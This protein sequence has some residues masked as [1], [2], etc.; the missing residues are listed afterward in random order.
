GGGGGGD[1][2]GNSE[3]EVSVLAPGEP[4]EIASEGGGGGDAGRNHPYLYYS[5]RC[6]A[7]DIDAEEGDFASAKAKLREVLDAHAGFADALSRLGWLLL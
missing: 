3:S 4:P 2:G 6:V 7:S 5:A 1:S